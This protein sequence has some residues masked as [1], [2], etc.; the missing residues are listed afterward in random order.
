MRFSLIASTRGRTTELRG[1]IRSLSEQTFRDFELIIADQNEDE[2][3]ADLVT[4]LSP[5]FPLARVP[6]RGGLSR[7]RNDALALAKGEIIGFP[8]DD[9]AYAPDL[10]ANVAAFFDQHGEYGFLSGRSFADDG[11]DS[12]SKHA[13][14]PGEIVRETI[15]RQ[16]I[17]FALFVRRDTMGATRFDEA[18]GVGAPTPWHSDEGPDFLLR[19]MAKGARGYYD[20][21][22]GVWH[23]RPITRLDAKDLDRIYRYACGNG[24]FYR[25]HGYSGWYFAK[26][27]ARTSCGLLLS[28]ARLKPKMARLYLARLRGCWRGWNAE[29]AATGADGGQP[30]LGKGSVAR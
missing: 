27:M 7:G 26:K 15:H 25:K 28:L 24:Y 14:E 16:C 18:M 2:R 12:V 29:I 4:T 9:C 3:V 1:L 5:A 6:S 13:K 19:L 30:A 17:E 10:L 11:R 8:D 23:P 22:F 20:P 21:A